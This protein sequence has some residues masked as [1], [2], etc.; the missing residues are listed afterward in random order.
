[1]AGQQAI[2][3]LEGAIMNVRINLPSIKDADFASTTTTEIASLLDEGHAIA[4]RIYAYV[5]DNLG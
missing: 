1:M 2:A 5:L 4:G 3:G